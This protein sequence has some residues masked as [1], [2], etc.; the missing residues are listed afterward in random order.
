MVN[1]RIE[2]VGGY[3]DELEENIKEKLKDELKDPTKIRYEAKL[4]EGSQISSFLIENV[5]LIK[6]LGLLA[7]GIITYLK[8]RPNTKIKINNI[9]VSKDDDEGY[10]QKVIE[11]ECK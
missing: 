2:V 6:D 5:N 7:I 1:L 3:V 8:K 10:I 4:I 9:I 11:R